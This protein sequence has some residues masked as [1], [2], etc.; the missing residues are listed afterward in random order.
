M[1]LLH[2]LIHTF[3]SVKSLMVTDGTFGLYNTDIALST[4]T[5]APKAMSYVI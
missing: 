5:G 4:G 3:S 2:K 1:C